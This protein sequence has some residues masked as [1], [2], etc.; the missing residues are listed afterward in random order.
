MRTG[1]NLE[2]L[3]ESAVLTGGSPAAIWGA[4]GISMCKG[5][6][7]NVLRCLNNE[8]KSCGLSMLKEM[9]LCV[10]GQVSS[11][12]MGCGHNLGV[13]LARGRHEPKGR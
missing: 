8:S 4:V 12:L 9:R 11:G 7:Q 2:W 10:L 5:L 6:R 3:E 13:T 1:G